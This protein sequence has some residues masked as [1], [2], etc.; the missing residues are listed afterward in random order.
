MKEKAKNEISRQASKQASK[1]LVITFALLSFSI[2][3]GYRTLLAANEKL[4]NLL[5]HVSHRLMNDSNA[6]TAT[7]D[8]SSSS[9]QIDATR[10]MTKPKEL[11]QE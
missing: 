5:T 6:C 1:Q 3:G 4:I 8:S 2:F 11:H 7:C 9:A 10:E